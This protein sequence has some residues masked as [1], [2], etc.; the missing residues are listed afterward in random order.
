MRSFPIGAGVLVLLAF[1]LRAT[2]WI[3]ESLRRWGSQSWPWAKTAIE[4]GFI[5]RVLQRRSYSYVLM[6]TYSYSVNSEEY[7]GTYTESFGS[8]PQAQHALKSLRDLPPP[9]RYKSS[10]PSESLMDPYRDAGL[11]VTSDHPETTSS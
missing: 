11:A 3:V 7:L 2:P 6:V 4:S 5:E 8:E 1:V 9:A 10:D